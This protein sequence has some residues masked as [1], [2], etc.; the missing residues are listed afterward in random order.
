MSLRC[1]AVFGQDRL[2][3]AGKTAGQRDFDKDPW[4]FRH[5]GVKAGET[6]AVLWQQAQAQGV[7]AVDG[8]H[9]FVG[10]GLFQDI[11]RADPVDPPQHRK[12]GIEPRR[13]EMREIQID[14]RQP[15]VRPNCRE[16]IAAHGDQIGRRARYA[17]Q[18]PQDFLS[19]RFGLG[20]RAAT[21]T[22]LILA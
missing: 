15:R 14:A 9:R 21:R 3:V 10:D 5:A 17:V 16:Q 22:G 2:D 13:E 4:L 8:M 19:A 12:S 20:G 18:T 6:L 7:P 11:R 1:G